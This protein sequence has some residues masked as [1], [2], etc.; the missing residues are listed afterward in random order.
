MPRCADENNLLGHGL[1]VGGGRFGIAVL[2]MLF[3]NFTSLLTKKYDVLD[4]KLINSLFARGIAP[5]AIILTAIEKNVINDQMVIDAVYLVITATII[6][7]SL[8][9]FILQKSKLKNK[10]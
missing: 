4:R 2:V 5:A 7:S 10:E 6:L 3:R 9:V 1:R 8:R